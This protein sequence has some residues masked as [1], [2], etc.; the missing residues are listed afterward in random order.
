MRL[1]EDDRQ[2]RSWSAHEV[3]A[4]T[5]LLRE[6]LRRRYMAKRVVLRTVIWVDVPF[7]GVH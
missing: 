5:T 6:R 7:T 4:Q 1:R 2:R 3:G